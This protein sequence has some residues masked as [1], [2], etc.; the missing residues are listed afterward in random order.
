M[1][2]PV[3]KKKATPAVA[4]KK[5]RAAEIEAVFDPKEQ[6]KAEKAL[7]VYLDEFDERSEERDKYSQKILDA[8]D[9]AAADVVDQITESLRKMHPEITDSIPF[10]G[11]VF[12]ITPEEASMLRKARDRNFLYIA[13]RIMVACS[14]WNIRIA[15]FKLPKHNCARCGKKVK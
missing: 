7:R 1:P 15:D 6:R 3:A 10:Q 4:K 13:V 12:R 11:R 14:E 8:N 9:Q 5:S 2:K